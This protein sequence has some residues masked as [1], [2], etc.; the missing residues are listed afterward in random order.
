MAVGVGWVQ[1]L[2]GVLGEASGEVV[3][4]AGT[5]HSAGRH[6]ARQNGIAGG[7]CSQRLPQIAQRL[8]RAQLLGPRVGAERDV[9]DERLHQWRRHVISGYRT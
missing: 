8:E 3:H 9:S 2:G 1:S 7:L 6:D 5:L 4:G